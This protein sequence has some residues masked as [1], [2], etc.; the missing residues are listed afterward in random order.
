MSKPDESDDMLLRI[1]EADERAMDEME[2]KVHLQNKKKLKKKKG[3]GGQGR[4]RTSV[5]N[6]EGDAGSP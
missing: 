1:K 6:S 5:E 3:G 2:E 4:M